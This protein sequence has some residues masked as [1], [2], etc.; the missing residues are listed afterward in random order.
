MEEKIMNFSV[1][2]T[3]LNNDNS[4]VK[5]YADVTFGG[6]MKVT[7]ISLIENA[8]GG[9]FISMPRYKSGEVD[10]DGNSVYKDICNPITKDFRDALYGTIME[11]Y[12]E[13]CKTGESAT[14]EISDLR[15]EYDGRTAMAAKVYPVRKEGARSLAYAKVVLDDV[16]VI[17]NIS[18]MEGK[19]G[20]FVAMPSYKTKKVDENGNSEYRDICYP[21]TKEAR[22]QLRK[23]VFDEYKK[24]KENVRDTQ[25]QSSAVN[26]TIPDWVPANKEE[27]PF[28]GKEEHEP[29]AVGYIP[30]KHEKPSEEKHDRPIKVSRGR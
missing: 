14:K 8:N 22:E 5:A 12:N 1:K 24:A 18:I 28:Q 27:L 20:P 26:N 15:P 9:I 7:N 2:V 13:S 16:F 30:V 25:A 4:K 10:Q 3:A 23:V 11:A 17:N 6:T 21:V 29:K 19:N